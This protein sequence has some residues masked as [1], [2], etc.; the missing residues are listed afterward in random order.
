MPHSQHSLLEL[1]RAVACFEAVDQL[2]SLVGSHDEFAGR[3]D[4]YQRHACEM[5]TSPVGFREAPG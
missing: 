1:I 5:P 3:Q 2:C 4:I